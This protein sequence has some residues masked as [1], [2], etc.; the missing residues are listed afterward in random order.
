MIDK[1][2]AGAFRPGAPRLSVRKR[3]AAPMARAP[4]Q[5]L[6]ELRR[7]VDRI[8]RTMV[9]LLVDRLRVVRD[10]A[11][12][13]Q[14]AVAGR[15]AIRPGREAVILRRVVE[16][17]GGRFPAG[18]LVRMW[19]E[20]LA[21]TTRAQG[22]L[23]IA[24]CVPPDRAELWDLARDHF[25][26]AA[27]IQ[28]T[29]SWSHALRL[30]AD[31]DADLAVLPLPGEGEPWW[32]S[33][34]DTSVQ[35]LRVVARL[36]F[37]PPGPQLEGSGAMVVGAIDPEPS[38]ADLSLFALETSAEVG[39]ARLLDHLAAPELAPRVLATLR[40]AAGDTALHLIELDGFVTAGD[41]PLAHA[42]AHAR[43]LVL[44]SMWL[45]GY[46]RPLAVGD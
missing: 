2:R 28:R 43:Q 33:L 36:P 45:G 38:G 41:L 18:T 4:D 37:G 21:A 32:A 14:T 19:R 24:A 11:R 20:L 26:A 10:I 42:L 35:P 27:P 29:V 1:R 5:E 7:E 40:P 6:K 34:L 31:G 13:K 30:V 17:A 23:A 9:E 46:A 39:R 12:I 25:G 3:S 44:R 16:Q 8:D 22:P 15:P